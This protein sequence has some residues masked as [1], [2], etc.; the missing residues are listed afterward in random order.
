MEN[1]LEGGDVLH[2]VPSDVEA[3]IKLG[4]KMAS[5][6]GE[7]RTT[8]STGQSTSKNSGTGSGGRFRSRGKAEETRPRMAARRK[9]EVDDE[10]ESVLLVASSGP[11]TGFDHRTSRVSVRVCDGPVW[12]LRCSGRGLV[13]TG[14]SDGVVCVRH[15]NSLARR[16]IASGSYIYNEATDS[17]SLLGHTGPILD[18]SWAEDDNQSPHSLLVSVSAD[19]TARLWRVVFESGSPWDDESPASSPSSSLQGNGGSTRSA[20]CVMYFGH[21]GAVFASCFVTKDTFATGGMDRVLRLWHVPSG[22][23]TSW[24][25]CNDA[26]T[27]IAVSGLTRDHKGVMKKRV[28]VGLRGGQIFGYSARTQDKLEFDDM[29]L[30]TVRAGAFLEAEKVGTAGAHDHP[31]DEP[32]KMQSSSSLSPETSRNS[33]V[34]SKSSSRGKR[35]SFFFGSR[36]SEGAESSSSSQVDDVAPPGDLSDDDGLSQTERVATPDFVR[37]RVTT[38]DW[39][40][41]RHERLEDGSPALKLIGS[42]NSG[43]PIRIY[44]ASHPNRPPT[45]NLSGGIRISLGCGAEASESGRLAVG[46]SEDGS[47][48]VWRLDDKSNFDAQPARIEVGASANAKIDAVTRACFVPAKPAL[49]ALG[50]TTRASA[51]VGGEDDDDDDPSEAFVLAANYSGRLILLKRGKA[52]SPSASRQTSSGQVIS[53]PPP[54]STPPGTSSHAMNTAKNPLVDQLTQLEV[55]GA[56]DDIALPAVED[57][58]TLNNHTRV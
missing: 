30:S 41:S 54:T 9:T 48:L 8:T 11:P 55:E 3:G 23:P 29:Y 33:S 38:L 7:S 47:V 52:L 6:R 16:L 43:G 31:A 27:S 51:A 36:K 12:A 2:P 37:R 34:D 4:K 42:A 56:Q 10:Q 35:R 44:S 57:N 26:I 58:D 28:A 17:L 46:G 5:K 45:K 49:V 14:G 15:V 39:F 50:R 20:Q 18:A 25:H 53:V 32:S 19:K 1:G 24:A 40:P 21:G 22:R 13:A